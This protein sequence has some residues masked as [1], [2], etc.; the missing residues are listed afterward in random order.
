M[1]IN[2]NN[3]VKIDEIKIN[4]AIALMKSMNVIEQT[5]DAA[6]EIFADYDTHFAYLTDADVIIAESDHSDLSHLIASLKAIGFTSVVP[7][8]NAIDAFGTALDRMNMNPSVN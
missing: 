6:V 4:A 8:E 7:S 3:S 2:T 5:A 1:K